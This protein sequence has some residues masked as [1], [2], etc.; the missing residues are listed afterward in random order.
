VNTS[1]PELPVLVDGRDTGVW[2]LTTATGARHILDL[3]ART[4]ARCADSPWVEDD[5][6]Y[7]QAVL[8]PDGE[9]LALLAFSPVV[10]RDRCLLTLAGVDT[11]PGYL[12]TYRNTTPVVACRRIAGIANPAEAQN[13]GDDGRR[14]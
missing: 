4:Y 11:Y 9:H 3:D 1:H 14:R 2:C 12:H 8:R 10:L 5:W 13:G 6:G 7:V